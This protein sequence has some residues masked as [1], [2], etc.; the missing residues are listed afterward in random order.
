MAQKGKLEPCRHHGN[1]KKK[2]SEV[3]KGT[4]VKGRKVCVYNGKVK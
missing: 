2:H 1:N 3:R 4:Q